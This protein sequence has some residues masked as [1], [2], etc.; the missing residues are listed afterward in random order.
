MSLVDVDRPLSESPVAFAIGCCL[1]YMLTYKKWQ[2][3]TGPA[4]NLEDDDLD[5]EGFNME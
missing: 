1:H 5:F 4:C 2:V 3:N